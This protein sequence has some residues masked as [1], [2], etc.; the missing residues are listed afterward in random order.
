MPLYDYYCEECG[1][2]KEVLQSFSGEVPL[3]CGQPMSKL[4]TY[5]AKI[6]VRIK[7]GTRTHSKGYKEGYYKEYQ[8]RL[9]E[10]QT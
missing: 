5:P 7:G 2:K 6:D 3:C 8:R 1:S 10:A 9:Q 4:P